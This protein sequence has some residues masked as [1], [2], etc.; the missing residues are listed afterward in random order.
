MLCLTV[1]M[2]DEVAGRT[3]D[4]ALQRAEDATSPECTSIGDESQAVK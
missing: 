3:I 1:C 2:A 4:G